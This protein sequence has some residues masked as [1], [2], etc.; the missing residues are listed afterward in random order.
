MEVSKKSLVLSLVGI[1]SLNV[2]AAIDSTA[3]SVAIPVSLVLSVT[4]FSWDLVQTLTN[5]SSDDIHQASC[6]RRRSVLDGH[7]I[8]SCLLRLSTYLRRAFGW[9]WSQ[10]VG[11]GGT[12]HIH[13]GYDNMWHS[14]GDRAVDCRPGNPRPRRWR[15]AG[16]DLCYH[17]RPV[18][19][20][21]TRQRHRA[22]QCDLAT[23]KL[24]WSD[25]G[26]RLYRHRDVEMDLLVRA[27][28]R[29]DQHRSHRVLLG[30]T[31]SETS[32]CTSTPVLRLDWSC[33]L[34]RLSD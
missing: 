29:G 12:P 6:K 24:H 32:T 27:A 4:T 34:R 7:R 19:T 15:T 9:L 1:C 17:G 14:I 23:W 21:A 10:D 25:H 26:R 31:S 5:F 16:D 22:S 13:R 30:N 33:D 18:D 3:L 11:V 8:P 2:V 28:V 20:S